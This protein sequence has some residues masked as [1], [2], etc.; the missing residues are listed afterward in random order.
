MWFEAAVTEMNR[1]DLQLRLHDDLKSARAI[2]AESTCLF[3]LV[4]H[5]W[6][7]AGTEIMMALLVWTAGEVKEAARH[8]HE[9]LE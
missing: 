9:A 6:G 8:L 1:A 5:E 4:D 2:L 3:A 7:V